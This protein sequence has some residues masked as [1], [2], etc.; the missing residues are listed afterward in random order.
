MSHR[1]VGNLVAAALAIGTTITPVHGQEQAAPTKRSKAI[2]RT[3]WGP[4]DL[5]GVWTG[6]TITPLQRP[7]ELAAKAFYTAEEVAALER[8]AVTDQPARWEYNDVW[9]DP[10]S[11][12][13]SSRRTSLVIDPS[14]GRIPFTATGEKRNNESTA[15]YG[16]GARDSYVD[17]D[18]GERC[19]TDG[20]P[21]PYYS[22][23][24]NNVHIFQT[25]TN[26]VIVGEMYGNRRIIPVD[27]SPRVSVPQWIGQSRGRWEGDTLVVDTSHFADK[28][29][30]W[31]ASAWRAARSTLRLTE[32]FTRVDAETINYQSTM[33]DPEMF[34]RPWTMEYPLTN[35]QA[36]AGVT[37]GGL[38]E[39]A[40]HEG[41]YGLVNT[42]RAARSE[43]ARGG[44]GEG[45][46]K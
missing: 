34:T 5:G 31:W 1:W 7:K 9:F 2:P 32:R 8:K 11:K 25:P 17:L 30:Y 20:V 38:F 45:A 33:E 24:N 6:T 18:T 21:I 16:A 29:A 4:P 37:V 13:V 35:N 36:A 22:G 15:H 41:N 3:A 14:D 19:L 42:L 40:C 27:D 28:A 10:G 44:T 26:V 23:Y 39:Y 12:M 43:E 46:A